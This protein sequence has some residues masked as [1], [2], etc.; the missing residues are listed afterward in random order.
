MSPRAAWRLEGLGY[1]PVYHYVTGKAD[2]LAAGLPTEGRLSHPPRVFA[3]AARDVPTCHADDVVRDVPA[4]GAATGEVC[5]VVN[6]AGVVLGRLRLDRLE[7]TDT[8]RAD[9]VMEPGP[10]TV[11]ADADL[12]ETTE[13]M[14]ARNVHSLI[15]TT[16]DGVLLGLLRAPLPEPG[17]R[18]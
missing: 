5:I 8:R 12:R 16:P 10:V 13:R 6:Q 4:Q 17:L 11:R 18:P 2:W 3:S 9:Q 1:S 14:H 7:S 15:V